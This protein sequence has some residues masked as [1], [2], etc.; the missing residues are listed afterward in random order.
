[1]HTSSLAQRRG[2]I[3]MIC[4]LIVWLGHVITPA[5]GQGASSAVTDKIHHLIRQFYTAA[6][7]ADVSVMDHIF[8]HD[9][10]V[11]LIGSDP[12]E[13]IV[14][15]AAIVQFWADLFQALRDAGYPNNGGLPTVALD[16]SP[17][18][19]RHGSMAWAVDFPTWK[20][21]HG[22]VPFRLTLIFRKEQGA[23]TILQVHF[24]I[25]VPNAELPI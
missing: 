16:T 13:V 11:L 25:G 10:A 24:S 23:W 6:T 21:Q 9:P 3:V 4:V 18:V 17:D 19:S 15:H 8:S 12:A 2:R 20:F 22:D 5:R 14:G 1:M 7:H